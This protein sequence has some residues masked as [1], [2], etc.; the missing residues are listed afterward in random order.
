VLPKLTH[1][2]FQLAAIQ[3]ASNEWI[4]E[5]VC[6]NMS[7]QCQRDVTVSPLLFTMISCMQLV[8]TLKESVATRLNGKWTIIFAV[9]VVCDQSDWSRTQLNNRLCVFQIWSVYESMDERYCTD[10]YSS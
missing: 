6:G 4:L 7:R 1:F 2:I 8:E 10:E 5:L 9:N 3:Q